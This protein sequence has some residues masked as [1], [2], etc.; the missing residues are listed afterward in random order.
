MDKAIT[1]SILK[2]LC[3]YDLFDF[4]LTN[5][6]IYDN[7][8]QHRCSFVACQRAI[9]QM[10]DHGLIGYGHGFYHLPGRDKLVKIRQQRYV[11]SFKKWHLIKKYAWL[12]PLIPSLKMVGVVNTLA[13][14]NAKVDGDIDLL[15][16]TDK[17][18]L[19]TTRLFLTIWLLVLNMWRYRKLTV[20]NKF[21]LSF[22]LTENNLNLKK[23]LLSDA[24]AYL[25][26]WT[27][28][29]RPVYCADI[30]VANRYWRQNQWIKDF[31]PN[32]GFPNLVIKADRP[33]GIA[34]FWRWLLDGWL[35][36]MIENMLAKMMLAKIK[37]NDP[38]DDKD[39]IMANAKILKFHPQGKRMEYAKKWREKI[40]K[41]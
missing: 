24:D 34:L 10:L 19:F 30:N 36:D 2:T 40:N 41:L 38:V 23:L 8:W 6:E 33:N 20:A 27:K 22:F 12:W 13:Y 15:I 16:I 18:R 28:W 31:L 35:G 37:K 39:G 1:K 32:A 29:L 4:P 25:I 5:T 11:Y 17:R 7:L 21:C 9:D 3:F 26:Y 14:S